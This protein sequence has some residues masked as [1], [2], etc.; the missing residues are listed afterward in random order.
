VACRQYCVWGLWNSPHH[1]IGIGQFPKELD[2]QFL[3]YCLYCNDFSIGDKKQLKGLRV[4]LIPMKIKISRTQ[5]RPE[6]IMN[7]YRALYTLWFVVIFLCLLVWGKTIAAFQLIL[8]NVDVSSNWTSHQ[9]FKITLT[10][11][12]NWC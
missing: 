9:T 2:Y 12:S 1:I 10:F 6:H 3:L 11:N 7:L 5:Q 8:D 4:L